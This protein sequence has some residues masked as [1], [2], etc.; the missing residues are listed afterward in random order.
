MA[1]TFSSHQVPIDLPCNLSTRFTSEKQ[2]IQNDTLAS[3]ESLETNKLDL[4]VIN[5]KNYLTLTEVHGVSL[6]MKLS[7]E[8]FE[9][10]IISCFKGF[11]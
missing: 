3:W 7:C 2:E 5:N 1:E 11:S 4:E 6:R 10:H 8:I 9:H